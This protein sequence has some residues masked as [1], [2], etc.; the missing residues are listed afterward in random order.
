MN[1][2]PSTM[3]LLRIP[4]PFHNATLRVLYKIN[5]LVALYGWVKF[6]FNDIKGFG[7]VIF[8]KKYDAVYFLYLVNGCSRKAPA[9]QTNRVD[10]DIRQWFA[11]SLGIWRNV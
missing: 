2:Q 5:D 3:N 7:H 1:Y 10:T 8:L 4:K 9:A 11:T 6:G